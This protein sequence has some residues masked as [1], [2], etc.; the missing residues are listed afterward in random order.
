M[1]A[2]RFNANSRRQRHGTSSS[3]RLCLV[4]CAA[5]AAEFQLFTFAADKS[6]LTWTSP[7]FRPKSTAKS[8]SSSDVDMTNELAQGRRHLIGNILPAAVLG[9]T[10]LLPDS[11]S[12]SESTVVTGKVVVL[13]GSGFVGSKTCETLVASG[14]NVVSVS[15]RGGPPEG[16]GPWASQVTWLKGDV[17]QMDL[18]KVFKGAT[19]VV[20][21]VGAVSTE[22]DEKANGETVEVAAKAAEASNVARFV[23]LSSNPLVSADAP[24]YMK[25]GRRAE[26]AVYSMFPESGTIIQP[27]AVLGTEYSAS[28]S[29]LAKWRFKLVEAASAASTD[30]GKLQPSTVDDV[31]S[32]AALAALGNKDFGTDAML[33]R[34]KGIFVVIL[35]GDEAIKAA[36]VPDT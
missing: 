10:G 24:G 35:S 34:R 1:A 16:V 21:A 15:R 6:G 36:A 28:P 5:L 22:D 31:A 23:L 8:H 2:Q 25:G 12:A 18:G 30:V 17:L 3:G 33:L 32:A 27:T 7:I 14:A 29:Q 4:L 13:G 11:A 19:A 9:S 20:S 26:A